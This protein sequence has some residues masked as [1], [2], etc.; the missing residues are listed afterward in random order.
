MEFDCTSTLAPILYV[1][2]DNLTARDSLV[3]L[4]ESMGLKCRAYASGIEFLDAHQTCPVGCLLVDLRMHGMSGI[5]VMKEV[6]RRQWPLPMI[7]I[8]AYADIKATVDAMQ[9][10]ALTVIGKPYR[11]QDLWEAIDQGMV[12]SSEMASDMKWLQQFEGRLAALTKEEHLILPHLRQGVPV[13]RIANILECSRRTVELR[14][15]SVLEK[16]AAQSD[17]ELIG[18]LSKMELLKA[19]LHLDE[20]G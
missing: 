19:K 11:D 12:A 16:M 18:M 15:K 10:G 4:A 13:K 3:M 9:L 20:Q 14:L 1:I 5:Q 17:I 8:S 2:D 6:R 7:L